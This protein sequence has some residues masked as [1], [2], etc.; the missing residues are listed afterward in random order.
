VNTAAQGEAP[1]EG[2][3]ADYLANR[4]GEAEAQAFELYCLGHPDFARE[5]ERELA[6]KTGM[7]ELH[8]SAPQVTSP[9]RKRR[10][11][12]WPLALAASVAVLASS[13]LIIQYSMDRRPPLVAFSSRGDIPDAL[14][15][16]AVSQVSLVRM[17]GNDAVTRASVPANGLV[18]IRLIPDSIA[19]S[20]IYSVQISAESQSSTKPLIVRGLRPTPDGYLQLFVPAAQMIGRTWLVSVGEDADVGKQ[21]GVEVFRLKF[22]P[23]PGTAQ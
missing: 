4:L 15:R 11:G 13:V 1:G 20:G 10:Y 2:V 9:G 16:S 8:Q 17:R 22:V 19:E 5:V 14:R 6:L 3:V 21:H 23:A 12:G 18:D 7:R